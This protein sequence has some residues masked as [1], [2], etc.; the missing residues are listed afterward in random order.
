MTSFDY[1][2]QNAFRC[3][4]CVTR[5]RVFQQQQTW[6]IIWKKWG[7]TPRRKWLFCRVVLRHISYAKF[8]QILADFEGFHRLFGSRNSPTTGILHPGFYTLSAMFTGE[9][10]RSSSLALVPRSYLL[11]MIVKL[12]YWLACQHGGLCTC[13]AQ[14]NVTI[15]ANTRSLHFPAISGVK[16][17]DKGHPNAPA[18]SGKTD[19]QI[20]ASFGLGPGP[21]VDIGLPGDFVGD[22]MK[23]LSR[24][25]GTEGDLYPR[26]IN[27]RR[28]QGT[29]LKETSGLF[30]LSVETSC[31]TATAVKSKRL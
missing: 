17:G 30:L 8:S 28:M 22:L 31:L 23:N 24:E 13:S 5:E 21:W 16:P 29:V 25:D 12:A 19:S 11:R 14:R 20:N 2:Y 1:N 26:T 15:R 18:I 4:L 7:K 9:C 3:N 27:P 10:Q 6:R